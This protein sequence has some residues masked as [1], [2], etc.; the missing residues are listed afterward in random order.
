MGDHFSLTLEPL[1]VPY[2]ATGKQR[3][4]TDNFLECYNPQ[5]RTTKKQAEVSVAI[6][7]PLGEFG[8]LWSRSVDQTHYV[9][10]KARLQSKDTQ[11]S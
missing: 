8:S 9:A 4:Q 10:R 6:T 2:G 3:Y 1:H 5:P 11:K 7:H